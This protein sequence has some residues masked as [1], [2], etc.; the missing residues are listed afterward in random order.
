MFQAPLV[1][2][3]ITKFFGHWA[4]RPLTIVG[5]VLATLLAGLQLA[6]PADG[7]MA[8]WAIVLLW[9]NTI[10]SLVAAGWFVEK[11][12]EEKGRLV[13]S[14]TR[15]GQFRASPLLY[16]FSPVLIPMLVF[17]GVL[18]GGIWVVDTGWQ[19][20]KERLIWPAIEWLDGNIFTPIARRTRRPR[21][22][23]RTRVRVGFWGL[24]FWVGFSGILVVTDSRFPAAP[25]AFYAFVV[26]MRHLQVWSRIEVWVDDKI[27]AIDDAD[28]ERRHAR[29]M[30]N[31]EAP[32]RKRIEWHW[33]TWVSVIWMW[34]LARKAKICPYITFTGGDAPRQPDYGTEPQGGGDQDMDWEGW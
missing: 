13:D 23:L 7:R 25:V 32:I 5:Y 24:T 21:Y 18:F 34:V 20:V 33:P 16:L 19:W 27:E 29:R 9:A 15:L 2:I 30:A 10:G 6:Q 31:V 8:V 14:P 1:W 28:E 3:L 12:K 4:L 22:W 26:M 11:I 17:L